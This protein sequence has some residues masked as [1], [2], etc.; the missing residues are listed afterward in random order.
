MTGISVRAHNE[1]DMEYKV[2]G[3]DLIVPDTNQKRLWHGRPEGYP[4]QWATAVPGSD[5]GVVLYY[6]YRPDKSYGAFENLVRVRPDGSI[7]WRA[8]LP[9]SND[10]YTN[11]RFED[12]RLRAF[13]W[14]S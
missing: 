6:Y 10:T 5:D 7:V 11:A 2:S 9:A 8:G 14:G 4:V 13:S 3:E 1:V 12:G